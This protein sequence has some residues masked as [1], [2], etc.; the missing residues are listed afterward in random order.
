M[1]C[2]RIILA[3]ISD[4][5]TDQRVHRTAMA[6]VRQGWKVTLIGRQL[7]NSLALT[8]R[9]YPTL[10]FKLWFN[11]GFCFYATF[12]IRLFFYLFTKKFDLLVANDLDTLL[13]CYLAACLKRKPLIYDS[14]EYFTGVPELQNNPFVRWVWKTLER[15]IFPRLK[16]VTTVNDSIAEMYRSIYGKEVRVVRNIPDVP[17]FDRPSDRQAI[18]QQLHVPAASRLLI[19]QGSGINIDRGAEEAVQ[20]MQYVDSAVLLIIGGG[21]VFPVLRKLVAD[22]RLEN[23]V[24][25]KDKMPFDQLRSYTCSADAGLTLDK[26]T[27]LN[28]RLSLPNKL[29]DYI[30]AGIPVLAS[31]VPEVK[32]IIEQYDIGLIIENHDPRHIA[33]KISSMFADADRYSRW[34]ANV[35]KAAANLTWTHEEKKLLDLAYEIFQ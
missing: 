21:D 1:E 19:L 35:K 7:K 10:R 27:N 24:I 5:V 33:E 11:K 28:Y 20:A 30:Q 26:P 2:K 15:L 4:L 9:P 16:Y 12:N 13:A 8:E 18:R 22:L 6:F 14:H 3:V 31:H 32:K 23:K 25:I 17:F 29:F 34:R